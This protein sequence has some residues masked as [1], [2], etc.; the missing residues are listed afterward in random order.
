MSV[1]LWY[2]GSFGLTISGFYRILFLIGRD[3]EL[4]D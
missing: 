1:L 4:S 3:I 2:I